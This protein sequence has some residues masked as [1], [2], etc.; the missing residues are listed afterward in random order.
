MSESSMILIGPLLRHVDTEAA[1]IW[2]ETTA[3]G[4][5]TVRLDD[6]PSASEDTWSVHGHHYALVIVE[7]LE[8]GNVYPYRV[9]IDG[10]ECWP[11]DDGFPDSAICPPAREDELRLTF[12]SCRRTAPFDEDH[13]KAVGADALAALASR[14]ATTDQDTWPDVLVFVGDQVYADNPS[15][16]MVAKL[17]ALHDEDDPIRCEVHDFE[18]YT[19][20]YEESWTVAPIRWLLSTVPSCMILDDH[21]LRDDWN[22]SWSWRQEIVAEPWWRD[23]VLGAFGSYW[24]YQHLGN[25]SPRE[26][27]E[28]EAYMQVRQATDE[29]ARNKI[30][31]E[32]AW[33]ADSDPSSERWSFYRQFGRNRLVVIDSRCSRTLDPDNRRMVDA[34]EWGWLADKAGAPVDHLLIGTSLPYLLLPGIHDLEGWN[35]AT[36][37]GAWGKTYAKLGEKLRLMIDL[38]HWAAFRN[39]FD[40]MT[41]LVNDVATGDDAPASVLVLSGDIHCSYTAEA[42]LPDVDHSPTRVHQLVMSP[43]RNPLQRSVRVANRFF[44]SRIAHRLLGGAARRAGVVEPDITWT[45]DHGPWFEN[46]LMTVEIDGRAAK[47]IV[48]VAE[49]DGTEQRLELRGEYALSGLASEDDVAAGAST[50]PG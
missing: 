37:E 28:E 50:V 21:D 32:L 38:E 20:L 26:L 46:G 12:G 8:A 40:E 30:V 36:A 35:E 41:S 22:S 10:V 3:P 11:I 45:V 13:L 44:C 17:E 5:V 49:H 19:W 39:S 16:D 23:R 18:E 25:L 48:E 24:I 34:E 42:H 27:R 47:V 1:T 15:D 7:G 43:F 31:D 2:V 9:D 33:R 6:G 14:M 4:T 29:E